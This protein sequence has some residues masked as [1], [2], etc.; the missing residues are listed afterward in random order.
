[1]ISVYIFGS[2]RAYYFLMN[3]GVLDI[4]TTEVADYIVGGVMACDSTRFDA[5][6]EKKI[7]LVVS[8]GALDMVNF[9][10]KDT[11]PPSFHHRKIHEHN[12]QVMC[13]DSHCFLFLELAYYSSFTLL[14]L[15]AS[16]H[17]IIH[18]CQP[19]T[20]NFYRFH[21]CEPQWR[22]AGKFLIL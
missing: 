16:T 12:E 7:P 20:W 19:L 21:L 18:S 15:H 10:A 1:M 2:S 5:I 14:H 3:K 9:G 8:V 4:T 17:D 22:R 13:L 11:I 6:V